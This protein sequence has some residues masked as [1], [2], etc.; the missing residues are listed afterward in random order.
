MLRYKFDVLAELK[1]AGYTSTRIRNEKLIGEGTMQDIRKGKV[2]VGVTVINSICKILNIQPGDLLEYV[3][4]DPDEPED[5][6]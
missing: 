4:D 5:V 2:V 3:P 1:A 6:F